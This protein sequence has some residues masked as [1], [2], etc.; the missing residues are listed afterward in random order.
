MNIF[1]SSIPYLVLFF[2][3]FCLFNFSIQRTYFSVYRTKEK[4]VSINFIVFWFHFIFHFIVRF[5]SCPIFF[6]M[7]CVQSVLCPF[8]ALR[9]KNVKGIFLFHFC[10]FELVNGRKMS[11]WSQKSFHA[12]KF[13]NFFLS[14]IKQVEKALNGIYFFLEWMNSSFLSKF[15]EIKSMQLH[16]KHFKSPNDSCFGVTSSQC[17]SQNFGEGGGDFSS[18]FFEN[19]V[20]T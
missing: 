2:F 19:G 5:H 4:V 1:S 8:H 9:N 6:K 14:W 11:G 13:M 15:E 12:M 10:G 18:I 3:H 20:S 17:H 16:K 7:N